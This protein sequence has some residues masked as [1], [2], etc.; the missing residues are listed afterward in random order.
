MFYFLFMA[1]NLDDMVNP[2]DFVEDDNDCGSAVFS[3]YSPYIAECKLNDFFEFPGLPAINLIHINCR[4]MK[5]NFGNIVNLLS[6]LSKPL[7]AIAVSETWLSVVN[8]DTYHIAGY[9]FISLPRPDKIGGGVGIF[10]NDDFSFKLRPDLN[11]MSISIECMFVEILQS[12]KPNIL[13]GCFYRPPNTDIALFNAEIVLLL[14][15]ID[16]EKNKIVLLAGDYNLDLLKYNNHSPTAEFLNILLSYSYFPTICNPTRITDSSATLID[17]IFIN[18]SNLILKSAIVYSDISDHLPIVIHMETNL[19]KNTCANVIKKRTFSDQCFVQFYSELSN[20][21]N[22]RDVYNFLANNCTAAAYDSFLNQ[23][24]SIYDKCFPEKIQKLSY[25]LTPRHAWMTKGLIKSCLKKSNLYKKYQ[26]SLTLL[27]KTC[28][29]A[30]KKKLEHILKAAKKTY[31]FQRVNSFNGNLRK[32][33]KLLSSLTGK[34]QREC[35]SDSFTVDGIA[36][37]DK[38]EIVEKLNDFF[39]NIGARLAASIQPATNNFVNYLKNNYMDSF[40]LYP[41]DAHEIINIVSSFDNKHSS[42]FDG[43]PVNIMRSSIYYIAEPIAAIINSSMD[44]GIFPDLLK[45]AKVCPVFKDGDKT[46]FQ[47]Y[48]P[49][50]VL[51]SFSKVFEKVILNRLLPFLDNKNILCDSQ[52][53]FRKKHSTY[54]SLIDMYDRISLATDKNEFSIG[55][56]IDLSKA[57]DTLDHCILL[58]KLEHY[59]I[60]GIALDWFKSYLSNRTQCVEYNG[61]TSSFKNITYG[62]PQGSILGPLLFILYVNDIVNCSELLLFIL[63]ADDTN[64]FFSCGD[65]QQLKNTVNKEL[66]K[67]SVW[68]RANKL[69]LNTKKSN[70]IL[71]GNKHLPNAFQLCISIDDHLL[72]QVTHTKFLGVYVD[73]KLSWKNHI[74]YIALKISKGLGILGR[75]RNILPSNAL[76]M[77]Y[78]TLVYSYLNYCNIVWGS[79]SASALNKLISLQNRAIR[80]ITHSAFRSSC[81]PLYARL[82]LL[83]LSDITNLLTIQFMYR[84]KNHLLPLSCMRHVTVTDFVRPYH[85]RKVNYFLNM[86]CRTAIRENSINV[87]GPKL[88]NSLSF[89]IQNCSSLSVLKREVTKF[90]CGLYRNKA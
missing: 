43:V 71:F 27:D 33:W 35:L 39:V 55:V 4:S 9:K 77:L 18:T 21:E 63:F 76:L 45:I 5:K 30:Y 73:A 11:R 37:T 64:L 22:W 88:W 25:K 24:K 83:K 26:K 61:V 49:I 28:Y 59:G 8:Q 19:T 56:F 89:E 48:R 79:A 86:G 90:Y 82:N 68:F 66:A 20:T 40:A 13:F 42:G 23:Y 3:L 36:I 85:I 34:T 52:Y 2:N 7:T 80:L 41:T 50:S 81:D 17:N 74:D 51:P 87:R 84:V 16:N 57:F 53:G 62:V 31:Y 38:C 1:P 67:V 70:F 10:V 65:I 12:H 14:K 75:V 32:T 46:V 60:R 29:M 54:M 15:I 6:L 47:N 72:E 69:S 78:H 44:T 58:K